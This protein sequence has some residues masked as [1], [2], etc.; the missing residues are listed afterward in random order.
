VDAG[1]AELAR[2]AAGLGQALE[3]AIDASDVVARTGRML[4]EAVGATDVWLVLEDGTVLGDVG[5]GRHDRPT[6]GPGDHLVALTAAGRSLGDL[7]VHRAGRAFGPG[8][9]A[10]IDAAAALAAG[11][12]ERARLFAE[13]M[14]LERLKS[15]F[16][17]RVSHELRT[18][19][20]IITGFID[21][22]LAHDAHLAPEQRCHMLERSRAAATRLSRLIE[23][24]L[25][26]SRID[27]GVLTPEPADVDLTVLLAEVREAALEPEQVVVMT[28]DNAV[29]YTDPAL[30]ARAIGLLVDNAI[31][32]GGTAEVTATLLDGCWQIDVRDRGPGFAEDVAHTAFEMFTRSAATHTVPGLGVGLP[33][34]RTIVEVLEGTVEPAGP[35]DG[36]GAILRVRLP[37]KPT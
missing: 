28:P 6:P 13:V 3:G 33:I 7:V 18:P 5:D 19:I 2:L 11:A 30:L 27:A 14:E 23:E 29:V 16:I 36:L 8:E 17:S 25:V 1:A 37:A 4:R 10:L 20:T 21:T 34:A 26:L 24:L 22:L 12:V 15:D 9:A 32:Y 31:K 35:P